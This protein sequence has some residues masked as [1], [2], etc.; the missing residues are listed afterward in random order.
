MNWITYILLIPL[1]FFASCESK[2]QKTSTT[3]LPPKAEKLAQKIA[4][5]KNYI[6]Y[7]ELMNNSLDEIRKESYKRAALRKKY[8]KEHV[9]HL[10][11]NPYYTEKEKKDS[12]IKMGY[13]KAKDYKVPSKAVKLMMMSHKP[14]KAV[15]AEFP[16][17]NIL[18]SASKRLV[19]RRAREIYMAKT[20]SY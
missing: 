10:K 7:Q 8:R 9:K 14:Y 4:K 3:H 11:E 2:R 13:G 17:L 6:K 20:G 5:S 19:W 18:D 1:S 15:I 12:L 16:L